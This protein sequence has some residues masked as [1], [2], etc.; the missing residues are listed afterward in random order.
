[1]ARSWLFRDRIPWS[2]RNG[3]TTTTKRLGASVHTL[4]THRVRSRRIAAWGGGATAAF[5]ALSMPLAPAAQA[6]NRYTVQ[7]N[8]P[9]PAVCDNHGT[10]PA[11]T[12]LQNKP[13]GYFIGTAMAGSSFDV[14]QTT[15]SDYHYGRIHG[16]NNLCAW[17]PPGA[18]SGNPTGTAAASCS[19]A[20]SDQI[21]HRRSFGYDFNAAAHKATDGSPITVSPAC[22]AFYNYYA[23]SAYDTG[24]LRDP[25]GTPSSQVQYRFTTNG[26]TPAIVVRDT[27]L[28]WVFMKR[29]CVTNWQ[30]VTFYNDND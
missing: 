8:S 6:V 4:F 13:C 1:M 3:L 10:I 24:T 20:I 21:G 7:P 15:S 19:D 5:V 11:G 22:G 16:N 12:W 14:H 23:S 18:L 29:G 28:G 2:R 26:A 30:N 27:D 17:I 9:K 25:A